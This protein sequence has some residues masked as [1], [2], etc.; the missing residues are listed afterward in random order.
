M[1]LLRATDSYAELLNF[2]GIAPNTL[3]SLFFLTL[4]RLL[5]LVMLAPFLGAKNMPRTIKMMFAIALVAIFL[6]QNVMLA[7]GNIPLSA[8]FIGYMLK[9]LLIGVV[10]GFL[11]TVPF[12]IA[13][14]AGSIIDHQR[15]ASSLQVTDPTTQSQTGP[16]GILY[17][18]VTIVLF[19]A[20]SG[21][22]FFFDAVASSYQI[23]TADG[24]LNP[25]LLNINTPFIKLL[26]TLLQKMMTLSIQLAGPGLVGVLL[27]DMFLGIAN[28]MA[29]QVQI[30]FLGISLKSWVGLALMTAAWAL[31]MKVLGE[32]SI[33]WV[34][35]LQIIL[36]SLRGYKA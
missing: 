6:P 19:F 16:I 17:N 25:L 31:I 26:I 33:S 12:Y 9:E 2:P 29:P 28:R 21:P 20:L 27:T 36:E 3:I 1:D 8:A 24:F 5:P 30:V 11:A 10:L 7:K 14:M 4:A 13:Q 34:K 18:Y 22:F 15:G 35:N 32:E 23:I